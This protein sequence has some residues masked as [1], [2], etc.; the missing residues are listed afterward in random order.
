VTADV[1]VRQEDADAICWQ[2]WRRDYEVSSRRVMGHMRIVFGL[3][4]AALLVV[5]LAQFF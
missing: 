2:Q 1:V 5:F 3:A 4:L